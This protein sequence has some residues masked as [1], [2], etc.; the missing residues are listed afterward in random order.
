MVLTVEGCFEE[1]MTYY[2]K[3]WNSAWHTV[4]TIDLLNTMFSYPFIQFFFISTTQYFLSG[5]YFIPC[6]LPCNSLNIFQILLQHVSVGFSK[7]HC[8]LFLIYFSLLLNQVIHF[9]VGP[10]LTIALFLDSKSL[11]FSSKG[12]GRIPQNDKVLMIPISMESF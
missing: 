3:H 12:V 6:L 4:T 5:A 7:S 9:S 11:L 8:I 2:L 1:Y 10:L